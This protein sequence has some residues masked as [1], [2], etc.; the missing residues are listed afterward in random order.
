LV[1]RPA[2]ERLI[3]AAIC[4]I[5]ERG[6]DELEMYGKTRA[7]QKKPLLHWLYAKCK[8]STAKAAIQM[9]VEVANPSKSPLRVVYA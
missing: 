9:I 1:S 6:L 4:E 2:A 3:P 8:T 5:T 7:A